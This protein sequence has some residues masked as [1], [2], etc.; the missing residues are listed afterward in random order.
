MTPP[1]TMSVCTLVKNRHERHRYDL[2]CRHTS[3]NLHSVITKYQDT[4]FE[5][6]H[7][8][9]FNSC[10]IDMDFVPFFQDVIN[11]Q[12]FRLILDYV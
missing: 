8:N 7:V 6:F 1:T 10:D 4:S 3:Y 11:H 9:P 12:G 5:C 2:P